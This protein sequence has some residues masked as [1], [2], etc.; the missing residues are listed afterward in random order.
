MS[1]EVNKS[2]IKDLREIGLKQNESE[3]Y[4]YLLQNGIST[5]PQIAHGT[6]IARTNCYNILK[7]LWEKE[8]IDEKLRGN[9]KAYVA[10]S[11]ETLKLNLK[12]KLESIDNL[13]PELQAL[14]TTQKNKPTFR[15]F[16]GWKEV[17]QIYLN[18]LEA[19]EIYAVGSTERLLELDKNFFEDYVNK[20]A[21]NNILFKDLLTHSSKTKSGP[22]IKNVT[23]GLH[24]AKFLP[25]EYGDNLTDILVWD[26]NVAL[27]ALEEPIFGTVI[28]S[29]PLA[30]TFRT[31]L[32]VLR[33]LL[34]QN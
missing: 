8:V 29:K 2:L 32:N 6:D 10:R 33:D 21:K 16:D 7:S 26:D 19:K 15:F 27:I 13:L 3:V 11:P 24:T 30:D 34:P 17:Q 23:T 28:T 1:N 5:P 4:L 14:H 25:A 12:R 20:V 31:I 9:R 18:S 22:L